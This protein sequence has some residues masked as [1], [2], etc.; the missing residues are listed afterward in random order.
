MLDLAI[1]GSGP[2]ALTAAIYAARLGLS[3]EV[4][5][6]SAFG[7]ALPQIS[8]L[9]NFPGFDGKGEDFAKSL[10]SQAESFGAKISFGA[11]T[12]VSPLEIDGES[13]DARAVLIATGSEPRPL[14][15]EPSVP[16]SYCA[17]CDGPLYKDKNILVIGGG[18]SAVGESLY[19]ARLAKNLTLATHSDLKADPVFVNNLKKENNVTIMENVKVDESLTNKFDAVFVFIGKRPATSFIDK[20][21]LNDEGYVVTDKN[22]QTKE[23]NIF[24]A[25]DVRS[26]SVKQAISAAAEGAEAAISIA[27]FLK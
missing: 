27:N 15:F 2:A 13:L 19:L 23:K 16:V 5:E 9:S 3:V 14:D 10:K 21:L 22:Y 11:C 24:A 1:I 7:G 8:H 25:G 20:S 26:G 17:L 4:F 12:S 18:N 6:K